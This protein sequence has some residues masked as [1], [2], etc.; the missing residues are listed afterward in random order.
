M[1]RIPRWAK[2]GHDG[3]R[4]ESKSERQANDGQ[5][6]EYCHAGKRTKNTIG[7]GRNPLSRLN[8]NDGIGRLKQ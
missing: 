4:L 3:E 1:E 7:S 5:V 8:G 6:R 2:S